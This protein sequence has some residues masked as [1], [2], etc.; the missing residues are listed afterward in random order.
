MTVPSGPFENKKRMIQIV[1]SLIRR[2][3]IAREKSDVLVE[4]KI[5]SSVNVLM[6]NLIFFFP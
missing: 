6:L 1:F 5:K 4:K 3:E 2:K